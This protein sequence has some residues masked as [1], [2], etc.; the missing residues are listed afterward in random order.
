[1]SWPRRPPD[2][3]GPS[4]RCSRTAC[5]RARVLPWAGE[6][7]GRKAQVSAGRGSWC[8]EVNAKRTQVDNDA[9]AVAPEG[10]T[11]GI[12][13]LREVRKDLSEEV[14]DET[15]LRYDKL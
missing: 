4:L 15:E 5:V 2:R 3:S 11:E 6:A 14:R 8:E 13:L 12:C 1:M 7:I 9:V 10:P